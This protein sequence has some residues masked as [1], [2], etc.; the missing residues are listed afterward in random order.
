[1]KNIKNIYIFRPGALGDILIAAPLFYSIKLQYP[2]CKLILI[3]EEGTRLN[4][5]TAKMV[6]ELIPEINETILY[7]NLSILK[8]FKFFRSNIDFSINNAIVYLKYSRCSI[9]QVYRDYLFFRLIG[10]KH[11]F[12]FWNYITNSK[13]SKNNFIPEYQ[14]LFNVTIDLTGFNTTPKYFNLN[15]SLINNINKYKIFSAPFGKAK[16]KRWPI[17]RY[18]R[19]YEK[20]GSMGYHIVICGSKDEEI[21]FKEI[22]WSNK[23]YINGYFGLNFK[24]LVNHIKDSIIYIGNDTGP[25]H[26][27]ALLNITCIAIFSDTNRDTN[28]EPYGNGHEILRSKVECGNCQSE[29]CRLKINICMTQIPYEQVQTTLFKKL[30]LHE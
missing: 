11:T 3:S 16:S 2:N 19:L 30:G 20:L 6:V 21:E 4:H 27:A 13:I 9:I 15:K 1:M 8:K 23:T 5:V 29:I 17:D 12:S 7:P 28:W 25:M 22:G 10:F 14:R 18:N 24:E 26:L